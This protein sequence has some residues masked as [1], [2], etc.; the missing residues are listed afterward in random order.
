MSTPRSTCRSRYSSARSPLPCPRPDVREWE[1]S[2]QLSHPALVDE[3][4][5]LAVQ[6]I[7]A[8]RATRDGVT[9]RYELADLVVCGECDRRMDAHWVHGRAGYRCR[10]GY[11]PRLPRPSPVPR[12]EY[13]REDHLREAFPG[14]LRQHGGEPPGQD[15]SNDV[16]DYLR[17]VGLEIV[18]G[19]VGWV[20]RPVPGCPAPELMAAPGRIHSA[21]G[22]DSTVERQTKTP[23]PAVRSASRRARR[24]V[25]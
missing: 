23:L 3:S 7:R 13:V 11:R 9:R 24:P 17:R 16:G 1:V 10:H 19:H 2:E 12:T 8:V 25:G 22:T 21:P 20:L 14:L 18:C 6:R 4:T 15:V 5:F